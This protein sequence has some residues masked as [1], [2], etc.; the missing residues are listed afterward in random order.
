MTTE[1]CINRKVYRILELLKSGALNKV[2]VVDVLPQ[3]SA[4]IKEQLYVLLDGDTATINI[5]I[6]DGGV[7][8]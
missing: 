5:V 3:P 2:H 4:E 7:Y 8:K 1:Q 6:E